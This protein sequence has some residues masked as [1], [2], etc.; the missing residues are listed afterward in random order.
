FPF[1]VIGEYTTFQH[2]IREYPGN[3]RPRKNIKLKFSV[4]VTSGMTKISI[5][6]DESVKIGI[7]PSYP[8]ERINSNCIH[9]CSDRKIRAAY[10]FQEPSQAKNLF[11]S[12]KIQIEKKV[13]F[14]LILPPPGSFVSNGPV[15]QLLGFF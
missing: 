9:K 10:E 6:T 13:G 3:R 7:H 11:F 12:R 1:P 4:P 2:G 5:L 14:D 8:D 15:N